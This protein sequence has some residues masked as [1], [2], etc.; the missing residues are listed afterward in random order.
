MV[1]PVVMY[2]CKSWT[3]KKDWALKNWCFQALVAGED[4]WVSFTAMRS[5]Q[6]VLKEINPEYSL[7]GLM[8]KL[9]LHAL[10][11]WCEGP[12]H[13]KRPWCW[14][15]LRVRGEASDRGWDGWMVSL[16]QWTWAWVNSESCSSWGHSQTWLSDWTTTNIPLQGLNH[17]RFWPLTLSERSSGWR[18]EIRHCVLWKT[19]R[20]SDRYFQELI[21]WS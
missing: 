14:E 21:L 13:W 2:G 8:L 15:R 12:T 16:S 18:P 20:S 4:S 7:E 10:A 9:K 11:T 3:I 5:K 19:D 6:S 17:T 1:F